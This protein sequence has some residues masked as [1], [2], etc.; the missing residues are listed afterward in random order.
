MQA[1]KKLD[2]KD[3]IVLLLGLVKWQSNVRPRFSDLNSGE[4]NFSD[5]M[6]LGA[7]MFY[8]FKTQ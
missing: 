3:L 7:G 4:T 8:M 1:F 6:L 5:S 2:D